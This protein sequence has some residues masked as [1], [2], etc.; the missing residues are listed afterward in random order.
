MFDYDTYFSTIVIDDL[1]KALYS[2]EDP[3]SA[4]QIR[5]LMENLRLYFYNYDRLPNVSEN[6]LKTLSEDFTHAMITRVYKIYPEKER[7][8][9]LYTLTTMISYRIRQK[10]IDCVKNLKEIIKNKKNLKIDVSVISTYRLFFSIKKNGFYGKKKFFSP[11]NRRNPHPDAAIVFLFG[12]TGILDEI[13]NYFL[14]E[15]RLNEILVDILTFSKPF[16]TI[17]YNNWFVQEFFKQSPEI[18][19]DLHFS[20]T[21][22]LQLIKLLMEISNGTKLCNKVTDVYFEL[23][24]GFLTEGNRE[25]ANDEIIST[26]KLQSISSYII[27]KLRDIFDFIVN[28]FQKGDIM[29]VSSISQILRAKN[30]LMPPSE[31]FKK[32]A[33]NILIYSELFD[34]LEDTFPSTIIDDTYN[35]YPFDLATADF[36]LKLLKSNK[37]ESSQT[38]QIL[39]DMIELNNKKINKRI[40]HLS[41][42]DRFQASMYEAIITVLEENDLSTFDQINICAIL[43]NCKISEEHQN[44]FKKFSDTLLENL[45]SIEILNVFK[46][47]SFLSINDLQY[48]S[49]LVPHNS[50]YFT[51]LSEQCIE[52]IDT[53]IYDIL[54]NNSTCDEYLDLLKKAYQTTGNVLFLIQYLSDQLNNNETVNEFVDMFQREINQAPEKLKSL[55]LNKLQNK[56]SDSFLKVLLKIDLSSLQITKDDFSNEL[57]DISLAF[58]IA[59]G[60][61]PD[62]NIFNI[63]FNNSDSIYS[64]I[65]ATSY[66]N[67]FTQE[68]IFNVYKFGC[69]NLCFELCKKLI[70]HINFDDNLLSSILYEEFLNK[71]VCNTISSITK[72]TLSKVPHAIFKNQQTIGNAIYLLALSKN[73][74]NFDES[75]RALLTTL[76]KT[77]ESILIVF[78]SYFDKD[79]PPF[80]RNC[81][82]SKALYEYMASSPITFCKIVATLKPAPYSHI[83]PLVKPVIMHLFAS[84]PHILSFVKPEILSFLA[85]INY[86]CLYEVPLKFQGKSFTDL[87]E[88]LF[89]SFKPFELLTFSNKS[90]NTEILLN[91]NPINSIEDSLKQKLSFSTI[92]EAPS[93]LSI[94]FANIDSST[95]TINENLNLSQY[96][97]KPS[98]LY[99]LHAVVSSNYENEDIVFIKTDEGFIKCESTN[100]SFV[101]N[102]DCKVYAAFYVIV[103]NVVNIKL[104]EWKT[105]H[106]VFHHDLDKTVMRSL[107]SPGIDWSLYQIDNEY[108]PNFLK[109][110]FYI[111]IELDN[112]PIMD[113]FSSNAEF[114]EILFQDYPHLLREPR[115]IH[116][117]CANF[118][119]L[120]VCYEIEPVILSVI[121]SNQLCVNNADLIFEI[122]NNLDLN[123]D[124]RITIISEFTDDI[125]DLNTFKHFFKVT[126]DDPNCNKQDVLTL[127]YSNSKIF[128]VFLEI[129]NE[130]QL[131]IINEVTDKNAFALIVEKTSPKFAFSVLQKNPNNDFISIAFEKLAYLPEFLDF[132]KSLKNNNITLNDVSLLFDNGSIESAVKFLKDLHPP[133]SEISFD[134]TKLLI[135]KIPAKNLY[136]QLYPLVNEYIHWFGKSAQITRIYAIFIFKSKPSQIDFESLSQLVKKLPALSEQ[137]LSDI[138]GTLLSVKFKL[139]HD[140]VEKLYSLYIELLVKFYSETKGSFSAETLVKMLSIIVNSISNTEVLENALVE[141]FLCTAID[142]DKFD[143]IFDLLP[144]FPDA[145][146]ECIRRSLEFPQ[147]WNSIN[148]LR[149]S[150]S[151]FLE[152]SAIENHKNLV[153][154]PKNINAFYNKIFCYFNEG[155]EKYVLNPNW[156]GDGFFGVPDFKTVMR[157]YRSLYLKTIDDSVVPSYFKF[158]EYSSISYPPIL[159]Y[160]I[161]Q[162]LNLEFNFYQHSRTRESKTAYSNLICNLLREIL[163]DRQYVNDMKS[164]YLKKGFQ[165]FRKDLE[166]LLRTE[167]FNYECVKPYILILSA[168]LKLPANN[169]ISVAIIKMLKSFPIIFSLIFTEHETDEELRKLK[170]FFINLFSKLAEGGEV[171][172]F[173]P[174]TFVKYINSWRLNDPK[175]SS[176]VDLFL[177]L[178]KKLSNNQKKEVTDQVFDV[179]EKLNEEREND[180]KLQALFEMLLLSKCE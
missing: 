50:I 47:F 73:Q 39:K 91:I 108:D 6:I 79:F 161:D 97:L 148:F 87:I 52:L 61:S 78:R 160:I 155:M 134:V 168:I 88:V 36:I 43:N 102:I 2:Y 27:L 115:F 26:T 146:A 11:I 96:S 10:K 34:Y 167:D 65:I 151:I 135:E 21:Q 70:E 117:Y 94:Q 129:A 30:A 152:I 141:L 1:N 169:E 157:I 69:E 162:L 33:R 180:Q 149:Y 81:D 153:I 103:E 7:T 77:E 90:I 177:I 14:S 176:K 158:L 54:E 130:S 145:L 140:E 147:H 20:P 163:G 51:I 173:N 131:Q 156:P 62:E 45:D 136:Q 118:I 22:R 75:F 132:M 74:D 31:L 107:L 172:C 114:A 5:Q 28:T 174:A 106:Q 138:W 19:R 89:L 142:P 71:C 98:L 159:K 111:A 44:L 175:L 119:S 35:N 12:A 104:Q 105:Y 124:N 4:S 116:K 95:F 93:I 109:A 83:K 82:N 84:L 85:N 100:I 150:M 40:L 59:I 67:L 165:T 101:P 29:V 55:I 154:P 17:K 64:K 112:K 127:I 49:Y 58:L 38:K 123:F 41:R 178:F 68:Q 179:V 16:F 110:I 76:P 66:I 9:M 53:I 99:K 60:Y 137:M 126:L 57:N 48:F 139:S 166:N 125:F 92:I 18:Q 13:R 56:P 24:M 170:I 3:H 144:Q 80:Y 37:Y 171:K 63:L 32:A 113:A 8:F 121:L 15:K 122:F 133:S 86:S 72:L 25:K 164:E 143:K 128:Q 23:I 42:I 46:Q 120:A